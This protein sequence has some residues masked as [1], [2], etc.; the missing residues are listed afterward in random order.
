MRDAFV[1][2]NPE[3]WGYGKIDSAA[4]LEKVLSLA[5]TMGVEIH[6]A[7]RYDSAAKSLLN[8]AGT[9]RVYSVSG[10]MCAESDAATIS[11]GHLLPGVYVAVASGAAIKFVVNR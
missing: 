8:A 3:R 5:S 9:V 2:A 11:V 1:D 7:I 4:G 6:N 10:M